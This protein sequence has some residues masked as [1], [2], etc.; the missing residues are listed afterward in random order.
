M[1]LTPA[2]KSEGRRFPFRVSSMSNYPMDRQHIRMQ[3][4]LVIKANMVFDSGIAQFS[5]FLI[6]FSFF[7][8]EL[9][10]AAPAEPIGRNDTSVA[11]PFLFKTSKRS[12]RERQRNSSTLLSCLLIRLPETRKALADLVD[13]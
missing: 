8:S 12:C 3:H 13:S 6:D 7:S 10:R 1:I 4:A 2:L 11:S 5:V 9:S